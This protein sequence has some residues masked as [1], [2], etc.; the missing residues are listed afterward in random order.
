[1]GYQPMPIRPKFR[2]RFSWRS[3]SGHVA[4]VSFPQHKRQK[5]GENRHSRLTI[6]L[7]LGDIAP[8]PPDWMT[9]LKR[10]VRGLN[11]EVM[12]WGVRT[13]RVATTTRMIHT[14]AFY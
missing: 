2:S 9:G 13:V 4:Q 3:T 11:R 5:W 14:I 8:L 1:M 12:R 6:L 10:G 7:H